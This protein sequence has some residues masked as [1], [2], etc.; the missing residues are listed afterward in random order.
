MLC[1]YRH[2]EEHSA[3]CTPLVKQQQEEGEEQQQRQ[4]QVE[5]QQQV[6]G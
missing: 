2:A 4:H 5:A 1:Q 6:Q 3:L